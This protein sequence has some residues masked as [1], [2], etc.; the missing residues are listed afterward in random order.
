MKLKISVLP[1]HARQYKEYAPLLHVIVS[2]VLTLLMD[3]LN[4]ADVKVSN[5]A[6]N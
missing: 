6:M 1:L 3:I 4:T 5:T 2:N